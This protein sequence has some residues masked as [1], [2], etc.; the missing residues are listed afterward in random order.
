MIRKIAGTGITPRCESQ[1]GVYDLAPLHRMVR[2]TGYL[3][4]S[5]LDSFK[6]LRDVAIKIISA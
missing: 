2:S 1:Y 4:W 6:T 5:D 3:A